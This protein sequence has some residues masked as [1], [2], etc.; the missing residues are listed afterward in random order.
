MAFYDGGLIDTQEYQKE[1]PEEFILFE[2]GALEDLIEGY[3]TLTVTGRELFARQV[4]YQTIKGVDGAV[5]LSANYGIREIEVEYFLEANSSKELSEKFS[6]FNR[7]IRKPNLKFSISDDLEYYLIGTVQNVDRVQPGMLTIVSSFKILCTDPYKYSKEILRLNGNSLLNI[8]KVAD[9]PSTLEVLSIKLSPKSPSGTPI[10][11]VN[12]VDEDLGDSATYTVKTSTLVDTLNIN[13]NV[14]SLI[15]DFENHIVKYGGY[16]DN[17]LISINSDFENILL[18]RGS[19]LVC[20]GYD[21][22]VDF[23]YKTI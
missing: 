3:E 9:K 22:S 18:T 12:Y 19:S 11:F 14:E 15:L 23:R 8:P 1:Y 20:E 2:F 5:F 10:L 21:I 6:Q 7:L 16:S 13:H 17:N 4:D